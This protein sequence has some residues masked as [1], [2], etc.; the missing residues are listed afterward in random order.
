MK[1]DIAGSANTP[2]TANPDGSFTVP[3]SWPLRP[4]SVGPDGGDFRLLFLTQGTRD[5]TSSDIAD[6]D[7]FVQASASG[8]HPGGAHSAIRPY[9]SLFKAAAST[10]TVNA[11]VHTG[12][13]WTNPSHLDAPIHWLG[14]S[15]LSPSNVFFWASDHQESW[16]SSDRRN[17]AGVAPTGSVLNSNVWT[18]TRNGG[19]V[20]PSGPLGDSDGTSDAGRVGGVPGGNSFWYGVPTSTS[21]LL[22]LYGGVAG[23]FGC[24][25]RL[26]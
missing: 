1:I 18:G 17:A 24:C 26:R 13:D 23:V 4:A 5:A 20:T 10:A 21:T 11:R 22:P 25:R 12:M 8:S 7:A 19:F 9:A 15:R 2:P 14:G 3:F 6:Y 16:S